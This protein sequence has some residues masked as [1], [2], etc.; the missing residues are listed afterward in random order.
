MKDVG[1]I[2]CIR[3]SVKEDHPIKIKSIKVEDGK[4]QALNEE[5]NV[6][7]KCGEFCSAVFC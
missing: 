6:I 4:N 7:I 1:E 3:L 2:Y 5:T